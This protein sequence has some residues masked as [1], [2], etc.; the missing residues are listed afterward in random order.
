MTATPMND[1]GSIF[2]STDDFFILMNIL[3][4]DQGEVDTYM[5]KKKRVQFSSEVASIPTI[6]DIDADEVK[7][8]WYEKQEITAFKSQAKSLLLSSLSNAY[9]NENGGKIIL[10]DEQQQQQQDDKDTLRG[11]E[12]C[13]IERQRYRHKTIQATVSASRKGMSPGQTAMV[14]IQCSKW[15]VKYVALVQARRD[16]LEVYKPD[17]DMPKLDNTPPKFPFILRQASSSEGYRKGSRKERRSSFQ[18]E[19]VKRRR[20]SS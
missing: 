8:L 16:E 4:G 7:S 3:T 19:R 17:A 10:E 2:A 14:S 18:Q 12:S 11:L 1:D 6:C 5:K 9:R 13:L 20:I 15:N